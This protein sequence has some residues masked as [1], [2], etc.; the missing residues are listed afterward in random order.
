MQGF[1]V[2]GE[3][4]PSPAQTAEVRQIGP[5]EAFIGNFIGNWPHPQFSL[6]AT[7]SSAVRR[8]RNMVD[9][10]VA[11]KPSRS[12]L[13]P[14]TAEFAVDR[15]G[16]TRFT[17]PSIGKSTF[18]DLVAKGTIVPVNGLRGF[19]RLNESLIRLGLQPVSSLP[20]ARTRT[21]EEADCLAFKTRRMLNKVSIEKRAVVR[22]IE[23]TRA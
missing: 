3:N 15:E 4:R 16:V 19:Y 8:V 1:F 11:S 21:T 9:R 6:L 20:E 14:G 13:P 2:S 22:H 7:S 17:R 23:K 12:I 10:A 5:K 18:H